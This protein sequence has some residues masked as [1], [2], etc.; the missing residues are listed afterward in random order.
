MEGVP[1]QEQGQRK[2]ES[3]SHRYTMTRLSAGFSLHCIDQ[4]CRRGQPWQVQGTN[5]VG[6]LLGIVLIIPP[7]IPIPAPA[8]A[9]APPPVSPTLPPMLPFFGEGPGMLSTFPFVG[10]LL[11]VL[12]G[13]MILALSM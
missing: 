11:S 7:M 12:V 9:P 3:S 10:V 2:E 8:P 5:A 1:Q 4:Q 13:M 6:V